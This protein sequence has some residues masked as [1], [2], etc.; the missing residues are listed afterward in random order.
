METDAAPCLRNLRLFLA[1][2]SFYS[3]PQK[4]A[5]Q[6]SERFKC[7]KHAKLTVCAACVAGAESAVRE[8]CETAS[9]RLWSCSSVFP[10]ILF[11]VPIQILAMMAFSSHCWFSSLNNRMSINSSRALLAV[12]Q[13]CVVSELA[14]WSSNAHTFDH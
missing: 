9:K 11:V 4:L 2:C 6:L 1:S 13:L 8:F 12:T 10:L 14:C 7:S 3:L 5:V